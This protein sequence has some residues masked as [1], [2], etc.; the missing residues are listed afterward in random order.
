[1]NSN[2]SDEMNLSTLIALVV[3][4][5][6]T[7]SCALLGLEEEGVT[8]TANIGSVSE[9]QGTW[10]TDCEAPSEGTQYGKSSIQFSESGFVTESTYYQDNSCNSPL[11]TDTL[12][13]TS[14]TVG[15]SWDNLGYK[16]TGSVQSYTKTP[17]NDTWTSYYNSSSG[18]GCGLMNWQTNVPQEITGTSCTNIEKKDLI[19]NWYEITGNRLV[20]ANDGKTYSKQ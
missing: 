17:K 2:R 10:V 8:S 16:F 12:T 1:L 6:A 15:E 4:F 14:L 19:T 7:S 5:F 9:L 11:Y 3:L 18:F 20:L 13:Y